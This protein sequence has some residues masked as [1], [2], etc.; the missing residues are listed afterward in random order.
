[1]YNVCT[2]AN[3]EISQQSLARQSIQSGFSGSRLRRHSYTEHFFDNCSTSQSATVLCHPGGHLF[4]EALLYLI[5]KA[6]LPFNKTKPAY[7]VFEKE[8]PMALQSIVGFFKTLSRYHGPMLLMKES[9][10]V[11][12][13]GNGATLPTHQLNSLILFTILSLVLS[14]RFSISQKSTGS[15]LYCKL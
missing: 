9:R 7:A 12:Q 14:F 3:M 6:N 4:K 13:K 15:S 11:P 2:N 10:S 8:I 1:M 5:V